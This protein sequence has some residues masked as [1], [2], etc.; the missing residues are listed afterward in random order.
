MIQYARNLHAKIKRQGLIVERHSETPTGHAF[1][2]DNGVHVH[3]SIKNKIYLQGKPE[4]KNKVGSLLKIMGYREEPKIIKKTPYE[5]ENPQVVT[6]LETYTNGVKRGVITCIGHI[7]KKLAKVKS[8][9][10]SNQLQV[11]LK[12]LKDELNQYL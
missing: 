5:T 2:L 1:Y 8:M 9:N 10:G 11:M 3:V 6:E 7:D 4:F 12:V